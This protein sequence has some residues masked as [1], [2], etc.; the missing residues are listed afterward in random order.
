MAAGASGRIAVLIDLSGTL[1]VEDMCIAGAPAALKRLR[2]NPRCVIR[3]VTNTTK[4]S[5]NRLWQHLK[6]LGFE[7]SQSEIFTSLSAAKELIKKND[8]RPMLFLENEALE[9]FQDVTVKEPNAV[10]IGLAPSKF[11]FTSMNAAFRLLLNGAELIAIHKGRFYR[12]K[13]GLSLGPGPFVK[14]LEYAADAEASSFLIAGSS[15]NWASYCCLKQ[16]FCAC[17][18][19]V[20]VGKPERGF[21]RLALNSIGGSA[22]APEQA[23]MIGDDFRD[24]VLG[25]INAG[26]RAILVRTGKY[27]ESMFCCQNRQLGFVGKQT[28]A[29]NFP[30][31][32]SVRQKNISCDDAKRKRGYSDCQRFNCVAVRSLIKITSTEGK[33]CATP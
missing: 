30:Q 4:Q 31:S 2:C 23:I 12:Q 1:H 22:I 9:D 11:D 14:A 13:D 29:S 6:E 26:M 3:F 7:I 19:A 10:V 32:V 17:F 5:A 27:R 18:K 28:P 16:L 24:D 15:L 21:F 33:M 25:A 8:L 20:V